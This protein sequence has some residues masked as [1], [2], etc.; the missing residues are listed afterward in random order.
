MSSVLKFFSRA[1]RKKKQAGGNGHYLEISE[2]SGPTQAGYSQHRKSS[3]QSTDVTQSRS[4]QGFNFIL[5]RE[6]IQSFTSILFEFFFVFLFLQ[7][8]VLS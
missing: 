7:P 1:D 2:I 4:S 5:R 8:T 6:F 3:L